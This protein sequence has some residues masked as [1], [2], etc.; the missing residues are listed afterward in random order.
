MKYFVGRISGRVIRRG[1]RRVTAREDA[2]LT[3]PTFS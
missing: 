2:R 1:S 3:R